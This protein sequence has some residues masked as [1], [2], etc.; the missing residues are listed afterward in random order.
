MRRA[1][2]VR[3]RHVRVLVTLPRRVGH[4]VSGG[5]PGCWSMSEKAVVVDA[6]RDDGAQ[7][8]VLAGEDLAA[9]VGDEGPGGR[10]NRVVDELPARAGVDGRP[11]LVQVAVLGKNHFPHGAVGVVEDVDPVPFGRPARGLHPGH[12]VLVGPGFAAGG[13]VVAAFP[14]DRGGDRPHRLEQ[15]VVHPAGCRTNGRDP[16]ARW[17]SKGGSR[18]HRRTGPRGR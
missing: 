13:V 10:G 12:Q 7:G 14:A 16:R 3:R 6:L 18:R 4:D 5:T 8:L 11:R 9:R 2:R 17:T 1:G 15:E